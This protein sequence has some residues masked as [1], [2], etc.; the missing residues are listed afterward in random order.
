MNSMLVDKKILFGV[1]GSIAVYKAAEWVRELTKA[2]ADVTVVMTE[3]AARFVSTLTFATLSG[4]RVYTGMF[5]PD[6]GE[7]VTHI[8]LAMKMQTPIV[9]QVAGTVVEI[10]AK[11][12][13]ALK[14]GDKILKVITDVG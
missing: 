14:P 2:G 3:S 7:E 13:D 10:H 1:S 12:G 11:V 6:A 8:N 5:E 9:S 4:N